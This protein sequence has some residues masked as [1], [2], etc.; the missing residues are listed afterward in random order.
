MTILE[1]SCTAV[2]VQNSSEWPCSMCPLP[3]L[4]LVGVRTSYTYF[5]SISWKPWVLDP[6]TNP[7]L[8][9]SSWLHPVSL[10]EMQIPG[11]SSSPGTSRKSVCTCLSLSCSASFCSRAVFLWPS[12]HQSLWAWPGQTFPSPF[13][14][15][16]QHC[17]LCCHLCV[18]GAGGTFPVSMASQGP[19]GLR[20]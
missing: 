2:G 9:P 6:I 5:S 18:G 16:P 20:N 12:I 19:A 17:Q 13:L 15:L 3:Q 14:S 11:C 7:Y 8:G 10:Q 4:R 1:V